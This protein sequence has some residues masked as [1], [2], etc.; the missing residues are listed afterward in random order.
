[1]IRLAAL[2][3][4]AAAF[5]FASPEASGHEA[6]HAGDPYIGYK[7]F[8]F[9]ILAAGLGWL[10]AKFAVPALRG[11]QASILKQ[12]AEAQ[13]RAAE[14][15]SHSR[16]VEQKVAGLEREI[17]AIKQQAAEE[18]AI[19]VREM[20]AET[21]RLLEKVEEQAQLEIASA[22]DHA[23]KEL[24]ALAVDLAM[25]L[26]RQRLAEEAARGAQERLVEHFVRSLD[27]APGATN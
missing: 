15:E 20:E 10:F 1:M 18:M 23:R 7:W 22:V 13:K 16:A 3:A 25:D 5:A 26:A 12:L 6:A 19:E 2:L 17:E 14:A 4:L 24:Q 9:A 27:S 11:Q 21:R 8:N